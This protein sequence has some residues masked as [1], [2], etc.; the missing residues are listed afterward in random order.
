MKWV[1][2]QTALLKMPPLQM[3][4]PMRGKETS[5]KYNILSSAICFVSFII[6]TGE[7]TLEDFHS[8]ESKEAVSHK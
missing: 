2:A 6:D 1:C 3:Q 4:K 5:V 7:M 8:T